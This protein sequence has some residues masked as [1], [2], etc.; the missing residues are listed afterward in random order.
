M[1]VKEHPIFI[2]LVKK[3][4]TTEDNFYH[5]VY[6]KSTKK[7]IRL[8]FAMFELA[9]ENG[10]RI[11]KY[12]NNDEKLQSYLSS[13]TASTVQPNKGISAVKF[14]TSSKKS[15]NII[16]N[17]YDIKSISPV[18]TDKVLKELG[19]FNA[20][21]YQLIYLFENSIREFLNFFLSKKYGK[22]WWKQKKYDE[23]FKGEVSDKKISERYK[24]LKKKKLHYI[25]YLDLEDLIDII[26]TNKRTLDP[27]F[28]S[29]GKYDDASWL[30][31]KISDVNKIRRLVMHSNPIT[32]QS[33]DQCKTDCE[34]WFTQ[35]PII[36]KTI[37]E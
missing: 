17:G 26:K 3:L 16:I 7:S 25:Y 34:K 5:R 20:P 1:R 12:I 2:K 24:W 32:S 29:M 23:R 35:L 36:I 31:T 6:R 27:Y 22:G 28:K 21:A 11:Q 37:E 19:Q 9:K 18:I 14:L 4:N 33:Y 10:V 8:D 30:I 15:S 13:S